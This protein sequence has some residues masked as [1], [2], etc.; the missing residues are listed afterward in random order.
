[1]KKPGF[2]VVTSVV[3]V[4]CGVGVAVV[5]LRPLIP[6]TFSNRLA[7]STDDFLTVAEHQPVD[8]RPLTQETM[9]DARRAG[10]PILLL[11]GTPISRTADLLDDGAF[12]STEV[13]TYLNR[14][15]TCLRADGDA[16]PWTLSGLMPLTRLRIGL[17][18]ELQMYFLDPGGNPFQIFGRASVDQPTDY[19]AMLAFLIGVRKRYDESPGVARQSLQAPDAGALESP[20]SSAAIPF[21]TFR[22]ALR[23]R[24]DLRN[25]GFPWGDLDGLSPLAMRYLLATGDLRGFRAAMDPILGSTQVDLIDGGFFHMR[26]LGPTPKVEFSKGATENAEAMLGL[27]EAFLMTGDIRYRDFALETWRYLES[28]ASSGGFAACEQGPELPLGRSARHSFSMKRLRE[29]LP[30]PL[31]RWSVE[32]LGLDPTYFSQ[33][34]PFLRRA[35]LQDPQSRE[36]ISLLRKA[37]APPP[38]WRSEGFADP[39]LTLAARALQTARALGDRA[40]L[41]QAVKWLDELEGLRSGPDMIRKLGEEHPR[42]GYLGD[43]LAYA[44]ARLQDYLATG[45]VDS[46]EHGLEMLRHALR[47]FATERPG[48][49]RLRPLESPDLL[50]QAAPELEDALHESCTARV[51]RLCLSYG[52]LLPGEGGLSLQREAN[53]VINRYAA[54]LAGV[55]PSVSGVFR[56]AAEAADDVCGI[57]VGPH[58][59][60]EADAL[61]RRA[62][63]RLVA[64]AFG[65]VRPDLQLRKPGIYLVKGTV[66]GPYTVSEAAERLSLPF[67]LGFSP[68][69]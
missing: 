22:D 50:P 39:A 23:A 4:L 48:E 27:A 16:E 1:M 3:T 46:F 32:R 33:M 51:A 57:A 25:G 45:R 52:R 41:K 61:A 43:Y 53:A 20:P 9:I 29:A 64:A 19:R 5:L 18:P 31:M 59:Q 17:Q 54:L 69:P 28:D 21:A 38:S 10:K 14:N 15:F 66:A 13:A 56:A 12:S 26:E 55:G 8:W 11:I 34:S 68:A 58:A 2:G 6:Q 35:A 37:D 44:D 65:P 62:P 67:D 47:S 24:L 42:P 30:G 49:Y 36:A 7:K 60:E 63:H 40:R